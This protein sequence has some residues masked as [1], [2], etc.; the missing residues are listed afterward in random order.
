MT[1]R[2]IIHRKDGNQIETSCSVADNGKMPMTKMN[3]DENNQTDWSLEQQGENLDHETFTNVRSDSAEFVVQEATHVDVTHQRIYHF[4][5]KQ[6]NIADQGL[7]FSSSMRI[8]IHSVLNGLEV[9]KFV[10]LF[11]SDIEWTLEQVYE[12]VIKTRRTD[13]HFEWFTH[14]LHRYNDQ[15]NDDNFQ[16]KVQWL[17]LYIGQ[18]NYVDLSLFSSLT[19]SIY[20]FPLSL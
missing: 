9:Q 6:L 14:H 12:F 7:S 11:Q 3:G 19:H 15:T 4:F 10:Y 5:K 13:D 1:P 20:C 2:S 8:F 17:L 16:K 18:T